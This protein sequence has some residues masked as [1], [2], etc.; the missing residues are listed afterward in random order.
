V[1]ANI[2]GVNC[3][4]HPLRQVISSETKCGNCGKQS[5]RDPREPAPQGVTRA[6]YE[7]GIG[8]YNGQ[9]ALRVNAGWRNSFGRFG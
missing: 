5:G 2:V 1:A 9:N 7:R 8:R 3:C 4:E 6:Q